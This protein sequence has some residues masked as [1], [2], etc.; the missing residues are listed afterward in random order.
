M[1]FLTL[2]KTNN[3]DFYVRIVRDNGK[4]ISNGVFK[5][6]DEKH[7]A[8][9]QEEFRNDFL[10]GKTF[11]T[12]NINTRNAIGPLYLTNILKQAKIINTNSELIQKN[13]TENIN[14]FNLSEIYGW[15]Y[16]SPDTLCDVWN[17]SIHG[18]GIHL[19]SGKRAQYADK[20]KQLLQKSI[21][22]NEIVQCK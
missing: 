10:P 12:F 2:Q 18:S 20:L 22:Y 5:A 6:T 16:D 19:Y 13:E 17:K 3:I 4:Y 9:I 7:V 14:L 11:M 21:Q 8:S 1:F 15:A